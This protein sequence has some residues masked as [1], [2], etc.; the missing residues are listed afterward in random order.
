MWARL[1]RRGPLGVVREPLV[2][3]RVHGENDILSMAKDPVGSVRGMLEMHDHLAG[4]L[5]R[6]RGRSR[7][8]VARFIQHLFLETG[9][10]WH[11]AGGGTAGFGTP[12]GGESVEP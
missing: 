12:E 4:H 9:A 10:T 5:A 6:D 2:I 7:E 11:Q 8:E 1:A 3:Y